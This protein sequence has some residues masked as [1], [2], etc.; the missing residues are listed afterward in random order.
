MLLSKIFGMKSN[1]KEWLSLLEIDNR[2]IF[3]NTGSF[4][5]IELD[6]TPKFHSKKVQ[7]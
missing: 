7:C 5:F 3:F 6:S 2:I 1:P 4:V